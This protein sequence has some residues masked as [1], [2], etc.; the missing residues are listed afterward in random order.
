MVMRYVVKNGDK[1]LKE[2]F[3]SWT[4]NLEKA[5][6]YSNKKQAKGDIDIYKGMYYHNL[7]VVEVEL[8]ERKIKK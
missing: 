3:D 8:K 7:K 1:Y 4:S 2:L 5:Y 6:I